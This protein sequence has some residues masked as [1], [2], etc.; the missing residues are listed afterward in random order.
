MSGLFEM[1]AWAGH[2][3]DTARKGMNSGTR[4]Y[5]SSRPIGREGGMLI[6]AC[7]CLGLPRGEPHV[8]TE[9]FADAISR[10]QGSV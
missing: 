9:G 10:W 8:L 4:S 3:A 5:S 2:E 1:E 6:C 7:V